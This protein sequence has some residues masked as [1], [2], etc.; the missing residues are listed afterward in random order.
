MQAGNMIQQFLG[1]DEAAFEKDNN[2]E[3]V[4]SHI[5]SAVYARESALDANQSL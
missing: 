2:C 3:Y 5:S 4:G 1:E